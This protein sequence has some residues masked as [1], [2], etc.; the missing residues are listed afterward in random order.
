[1]KGRQIIALLN[2]GKYLII[3]DYRCGKF[4]AAM[5]NTV[6]HRI[7]LIQRSNYPC[8]RIRQLLDYQP[9]C[10]CVIRHI[11]LHPGLLAPCRLVYDRT[12]VNSDSLT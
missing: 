7:D 8:L 10:L 11:H 9:D 12:P 6:S 5:H 1:M 3:Q 2:R 4:L